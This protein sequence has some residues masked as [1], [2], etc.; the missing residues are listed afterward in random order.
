MMEMGKPRRGSIP[1]TKKELAS[2][3]FLIHYDLILPVKLNC[4]AS[5]MGIGAVLSHQIKDVTE[6]VIAF[7]SSSLTKEHLFQIAQM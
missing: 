2:T 4:D 6:R 7:A 1:A 3:K 5:S